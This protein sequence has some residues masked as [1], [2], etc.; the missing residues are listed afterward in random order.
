MPLPYTTKILGSLL[1]FFSA[2]QFLPGFV[3]YF[4]QEQALIETFFLTGFITFFIGFLFYIL[5]TNE[6]ASQPPEQ[7]FSLGLMKCLIQFCF[8]DIFCNG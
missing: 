8:T 1:M 5:A 7:L 4:Y 3:A 2:A 6:K